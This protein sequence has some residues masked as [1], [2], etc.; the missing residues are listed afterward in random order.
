MHCSHISIPFTLICSI[1][2]FTARALGCDFMVHYGHSC[3]VPVDVTDIKCLYVFVEISIDLDHFVRVVQTNFEPTQALV[4]VSTVQFISSAHSAKAILMDLHGFQNIT[5][6][7]S[8][9]LS[10]GEILGCTAPTLKPSDACDAFLYLGDGRFHLEA[11]MI[12]NPN[13]PAYRYDPYD[14]VL[15][16]EYY[17]MEKMLDLRHSAIK[18]SRNAKRFGIILGTLGRQGNLSVLDNLIQLI[19]QHVPDATVHKLLMS[20]IFPQKLELMDDLVDVWI[21]IACPRLSIDWGHFFR[22]P[23]LNPY[24]AAQLFVT[25]PEGLSSYPMDFYATDSSGNWTPNHPD[26][27]AVKKAAPA[28][29]IKFSEWK[30]RM[31]DKKK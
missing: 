25:A 13:I 18:C 30:S 6:P 14:Q 7:Q 17:D 21:Q 9:P 12:A 22:K 16:Q 4:I 31:K 2:D 23:L 20:E 1:D 11:M 27:A 19:R 29:A 28:K 8:K 10:S 5:I 24:E 3:L 26:N 15:S